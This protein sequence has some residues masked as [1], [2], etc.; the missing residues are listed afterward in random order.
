MFGEKNIYFVE[1]YQITTGGDIAEV[2]TENVGTL[3]IISYHKLYMMF[4][5]HKATQLM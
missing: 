5:L 4:R 2:S 1:N 3:I